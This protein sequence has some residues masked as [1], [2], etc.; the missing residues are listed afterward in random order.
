MKWETEGC[1]SL[2]PVFKEKFFHVF[3][4]IRSTWS[5]WII[6]FDCCFSVW[7]C[8]RISAFHSTVSGI[9]GTRQLYLQDSETLRLER[10]KKFSFSS[11]CKKPYR[12]LSSYSWLS[13]PFS[14]LFAPSFH[15]ISWNCETHLTEPHW[16]TL[17]RNLTVSSDD[18][19][20]DGEVST[21]GL[22]FAFG[23]PLLWVSANIYIFKS[24]SCAL[25]QMVYHWLNLCIQLYMH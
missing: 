5:L 2:I 16:V 10:G 12:V 8:N 22:G 13:K 25:K 11:V 15:F 6:V 18:W 9:F 14:F 7:F 23:N 17:W 4:I 1:F 24:D 20:G 3:F 21:T 19:N